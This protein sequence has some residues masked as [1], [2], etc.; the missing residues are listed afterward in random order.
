MSDPNEPTDPNIQRTPDYPPHPDY[1]AQPPGSPGYPSYPQGNPPTQPQQSYPYPQPGAQPY[2]PY[3]PYPGQYAPPP[4]P[5]KRSNRTLWIVLGSVGAA[6]ILICGVCAF[7][8]IALGGQIGKALGP[9]VG[10]SVT[11]SNF[12]LAEQEQDY[13]TAYGQFSSSLQDRLPE[14]TFITNAQTHDT[15]DGK[16][17]DCST[18]SSGSGSTSISS[19]TVVLTLRVI[20]VDSPATTGSV[21]L[22]KEGNN[23]K[24][25]S[26]DPS[27]NLT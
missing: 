20:R 11:L 17:T 22:V 12:C 1:Y 7:A 14:E 6:L 27:L 18:S 13:S 4:M 24:I 10:A 21:T 15:S 26:I 2:P 23:Y 16:V 9:V 19:D 8:V 3:Q 5:P 25:D